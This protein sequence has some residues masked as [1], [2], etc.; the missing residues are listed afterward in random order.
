MNL[1]N[2][3]NKN[4]NQWE[5]LIGRDTNYRVYAYPGPEVSKD[6]R[7]EHRPYHIH[8]YSPN[9]RNLRVNLEN[10]E[11]MDNG[12]LIPK[13]LKKYIKENQEE[14]LKKTK[15]IFHIGKLGREYG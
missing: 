6:G 8:I 4:Q 13:N 11:S 10:L 1:A 12:K 9:I 14:L 15:D 3:E 5:F 7:V 2:Y